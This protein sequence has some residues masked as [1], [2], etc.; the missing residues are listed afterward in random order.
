MKPSTRE[1]IKGT[2]LRDGRGTAEL[3]PAARR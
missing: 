1:N 3:G 2:F